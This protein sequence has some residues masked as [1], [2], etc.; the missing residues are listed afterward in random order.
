MSD[1]PK[2]WMCLVIWCLC[3]FCV[4]YSFSVFSLIIQLQTV[5]NNQKGFVSSLHHK[6]V[7]KGCNTQKHSELGE[8]GTRT[9][10]QTHTV[11]GEEKRARARTHT[12]TH[13]RRHEHAHKGTHWLVSTRT[14]TH[15]WQFL[16]TIRTN[17]SKVR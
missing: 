9:H 13:R 14:Q 15:C 12:H 10:T 3:F 1:H 6:V 2:A 11:R 17:F 4:S 7:I 5:C 16:F 8:W